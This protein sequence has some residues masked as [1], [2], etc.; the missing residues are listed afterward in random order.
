MFEQ[1]HQWSERLA[2]SRRIIE[3]TYGFN[4]SHTLSLS[5]FDYHHQ[6]QKESPDD[7]AVRFQ[8]EVCFETGRVAP[9]RVSE[10]KGVDDLSVGP[11]KGGKREGVGVGHDDRRLEGGNE[12]VQGIQTWY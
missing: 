2:A 11:E 3:Q 7:D 5:L 6:P 8:L 4:S 12:D 1:G 9:M 10:E